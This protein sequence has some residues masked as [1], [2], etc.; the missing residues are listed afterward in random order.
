MVTTDKREGGP[1]VEDKRDEED[2]DTE[3][4]DVDKREG[5]RFAEDDGSVED[6]DD[7]F[8]EE[9]LAPTFSETLAALFFFFC[10]SLFG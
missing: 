4:D 5:A 8:I 3:E 6:A 1:V 10:S 7:T 2:P 9:C